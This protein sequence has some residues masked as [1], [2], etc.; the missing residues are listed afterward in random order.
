MV[1][2]QS[3]ETEEADTMFSSKTD[4]HHCAD[5][6]QVMNHQIQA[7]IDMYMSG[8]VLSLV[9]CS[10]LHKLW[11]KTSLRVE[12]EAELNIELKAD[13]FHNRFFC[14]CVGLILL[15]EKIKY[16]PVKS[17]FNYF[18]LYM[19]HSYTVVVNVPASCLRENVWGQKL[20]L[21][22]SK[23]HHERFS[24]ERTF[25]SIFLFLEVCT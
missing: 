2:N 21:L 23:V 8:K 24:N 4:H 13:K 11:L 25:I 12:K 1:K 16:I 14:M 5:T 10:K 18:E 19:M 9:F 3:S 20:L 7:E 15:F 22:R 17:M 6:R